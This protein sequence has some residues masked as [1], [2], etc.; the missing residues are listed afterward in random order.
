M[1]SA[2]QIESFVNPVSMLEG[3]RNMVGRSFVLGLPNALGQHIVTLGDK[4]WFIDVSDAKAGDRVRVTQ[5]IDETLVVE[6]MA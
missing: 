4:R 6:R 2:V 1:T 5:M 3:W